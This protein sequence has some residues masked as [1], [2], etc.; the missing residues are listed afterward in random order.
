VRNE[1]KGNEQ[2]EKEESRIPAR[3]PLIPGNQ[4]RIHWEGDSE[5]KISGKKTARIRASF[6]YFSLM[7]YP[8]VPPFTVLTLNNLP[9]C[10]SLLPFS[11]PS[12][13]SDFFS[14]F[15]ASLPFFIFL[16]LYLSPT[17]PSSTS[18]S[19][20]FHSGG[21]P[22]TRTELSHRCDAQV[23]RIL[24]GRHSS[25]PL[26]CLTAAGAEIAISGYRRKFSRS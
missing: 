21:R 12:T 1:E 20:V 15:T 19:P 14:L 16:S 9:Y 8:L 18:I 7:A 6:R 17:T 4:G 10:V 25:L 5:S 3:S 26:S 2:G 22:V 24:E 23:E 11:L 13:L